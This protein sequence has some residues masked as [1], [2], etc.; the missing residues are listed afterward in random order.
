MGI[1]FPHEANLKSFC[2]ERGLGAKDED[3]S[4][5]CEDQ[6]VRDAVLEEANSVDIDDRSNSWRASGWNYPDASAGS[7]TRSAFF[8]GRDE[9]VL[10]ELREAL[11]DND[12]DAAWAERASSFS[13]VVWIMTRR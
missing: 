8:G 3:F 11:G 10:A 2:H 12:F 6:K 1:A 7:E 13:F 9:S 5:L 4:A